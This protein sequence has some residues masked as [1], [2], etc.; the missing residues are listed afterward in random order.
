MLEQ[1]LLNEVRGILEMGIDP[2]LYALRTIGYRES[3]AFLQ[4]EFDYHEM[5]RLIKRNSRRYAKRQLTWFRRYPEFQ[6][7]DITSTTTACL[8]KN[9][10]SDHS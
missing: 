1:G 2:S 9:Y 3:I 8:R 7:F 10:V 4:G 6:W 5:V